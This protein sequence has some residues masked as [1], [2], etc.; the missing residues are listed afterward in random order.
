M[1]RGWLAVGGLMAVLLPGCGFSGPV[2]RSGWPKARSDAHATSPQPRLRPSAEAEPLAAVLAA[3]SRTPAFERWLAEFRPRARAAGISQAT[4]DRAFRNAV[5]LPDVIARDRNQAEFNRTVWDYLDSAV[6]DTRIAN[7]RKAMAENARALDAI[8]ARY[9]VDKAVVVAIWGMESAYGTR[10]GDTP[11]IS[12]LATL[13]EDGR[14]GQFFEEQLIAALKILQNGDVTPEAMTG[15]WAGAMGH[16]QF[17]PTSY[18]AYAA[19]FGGDGRRDIWSDD[20]TDAL[21]STANYL[22]RSGWKTGQPWGVEVILPAGFNFAQAGKSNRHDV[23]YWAQAGV[24]AASGGRLPDAG[25]AA[26]LMPAGANGPALMIFDN[27][28]VI[29]RYNSADSYVIGVG[30]LADRIKGAGPFRSRWPR[31]ERALTADERRELQERLTSAGF[32]TRG[33][34]GRIGP[35]TISAIQNWQRRNGRVPDGYASIDLLHNLR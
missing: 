7:G 11:L 9:G 25:A 27:F 16:T 26:I 5:Y 14:R 19:D 34:D 2:E 28:R 23:S 32:D 18:L 24:R 29:S 8:E 4:F 17:I 22:A 1:M 13:A 35:D 20:P 10:R 6:S 33:V 30:H 21:A 3:P 12:A 15:S 31:D